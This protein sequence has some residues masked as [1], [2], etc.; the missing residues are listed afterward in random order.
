MRLRRQSA[1]IRAAFLV[2]GTTL[3]VLQTLA[4]RHWMT[5][6]AIAYLDLSDA[7]FPNVNWDRIINGVWSPLYPFLLGL[8]RLMRPAP[9]HEIVTSHL[10]NLPIFL[11]TFAAFDFFLRSWLEHNLKNNQEGDEGSERVRLPDWAYLVIGYS[12]FLW[13]A[14][15]QITL[16]DLRPDMLMAALVFLAVGL[17]FRMRQ[18]ATWGRFLL[19]GVVLGVGYLAKAPVLPIGLIILAAGV[20]GAKERVRALPMAVAAALVMFAVGSLY[21]VPL[22][23]LRGYFTL[24]ESSSFNYLAH[25]NHIGPEWYV[26]DVGEG[27]G[28]LLHKPTKIFDVPRTFEFPFE[29][30]ITHPLRFDP[31]YWTQGAKPRFRIMSQLFAV[32]NNFMVYRDIIEATGGL[33][34]SFVILLLLSAHRKDALRE[35]ASQ[36]PLWS[37]GVAGLLMYLAVHVEGRYVGL[38]FVLFW[39]GLIGGIRAPRS[40]MPRVSF[41]VALG[42]SLS[43]LVPASAKIAYDFAY[44]IRSYSDSEGEAARELVRLGLKPGDRVARISP[45][46]TDLAWVRITRTSVV[47][48]V[49]FAVANEFWSAGPD[50]QEQI[51]R[52]LARSGAKFVVAH[53]SGNIVPPGWHRLRKTHYWVQALNAS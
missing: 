16:K 14:L 32:I 34:A 15:T 8:G 42:I 41:A 50:S 9:D 28:Y 30:N 48:E 1:T 26:Q 18:G 23:H 22:S 39:M 2:L 46:L 44:N 6:D 17:L 45:F 11:L 47:A 36:W 10:V 31:S 4:Y 37:I 7:L 20:W 53:T 33:V 49:D 25:V 19:L 38:F 43:L 35:I 12:L 27:S 21:F 24:G 29:S 5:A 3:A 51:L 40:L 13:A 52:A